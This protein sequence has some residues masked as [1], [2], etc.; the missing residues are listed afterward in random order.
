MVDEHQPDGQEPSELED[1]R[2]PD[3]D[4]RLVPDDPG[5]AFCD[6]EPERLSWAAYFGAAT[7]LLAGLV[8]S[9]IGSA[10][11]FHVW[12]GSGWANVFW[13][14][15]SPLLTIL[16]VIVGGFGFHRWLR[17]EILLPVLV[18]F[19]VLVTGVW[20]ASGPVGFPWKALPA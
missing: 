19:A 7:G 1:A 3:T 2:G 15:A 20:L 5:E 16:G 18:F 8:I 4:D 6:R 11:L 10:V 17:G 12:P 14:V 13:Q 9:M